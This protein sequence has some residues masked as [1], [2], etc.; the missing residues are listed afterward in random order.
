[1]KVN[2]STLANIRMGHSIRGSIKDEPDGDAVVVRMNNVDVAR[3]IVHEDLARMK[4]P[5]KKA[6]QYLEA[7]EILFTARGR[8]NHAIFV[9]AEDIEKLGPT[10]AAPQFF[11]LSVKDQGVVPEYLA[12]FINSRQGQLYFESRAEGVT[13]Q[14][15]TRSSLGDLPVD[16]PPLSI[17]NE[18]I[19]MNRLWQHERDLNQE[20][21]N[22][23]QIFLENMWL[24]MVLR[25]A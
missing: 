21:I 23:R 25:E 4:L 17:Q 15:I 14:N 12:W 20:Y 18:I 1:M 8:N 19:E 5:G 24:D 3:G 22:K 13:V 9:S 6:P 7:G 11:V 2:L 10:V 16:A